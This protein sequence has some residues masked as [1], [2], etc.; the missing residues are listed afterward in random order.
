[1]ATGLISFLTWN[2][3]GLN[4]PIKRALVFQYLHKQNCDIMCLQKTHVIHKKALLNRPWI[5]W[6]G[7][8]VSILIHCRIYFRL[9][10]VTLDRDGR[11]VLLHCLLFQ[12]PFIL[13]GV[14]IPPPYSSAVVQEILESVVSFSHTPCIWL[15]E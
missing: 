13:I 15:G 12:K 7:L 10:S 1:M 11:Y 8:G 5:G 3:R 6:S 9:L 14:Y 4:D 2:V